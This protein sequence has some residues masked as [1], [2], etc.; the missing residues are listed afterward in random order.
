MWDSSVS[1]IDSNSTRLD[2][3]SLAQLTAKAPGN[4]CTLGS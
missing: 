4:D 2:S 1:P 3:L